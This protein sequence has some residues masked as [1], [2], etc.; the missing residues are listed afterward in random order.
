MYGG[1]FAQASNELI[2]TNL[3]LVLI[4]KG[5]MIGNVKEILVFPLNQVKV[6]NQQAQA[7]LG[8]GAG[9]L[10]S[11][12]IYFLNGQEEFTFQLGGKAKIKEWIRMIN[13]AV[14]GQ[15]GSTPTH[16]DSSMAIP[17]AD[18]VAEMFADTIGVFK[19]RLGSRP[20]VQPIETAGKCDACGAPVTGY[21]GQTI[22]CTYC[23][24]AQHL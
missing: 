1:R 8:K 11:L 10:N 2:L 22:T 16:Q 3:N 21:A 18:F 12:V 13:Q 7:S 6:Y 19:S 4:K 14:I 15:P 9:G 20:R 17:G 23:G 5:M 24:L